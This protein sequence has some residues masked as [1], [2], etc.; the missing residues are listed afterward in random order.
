MVEFTR[1]ALEMVLSSTITTRTLHALPSEE[2]NVITDEWIVVFVRLD[3]ITGRMN[4]FVKAP[5]N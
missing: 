5:K 3:E 2:G 1:G 4:I